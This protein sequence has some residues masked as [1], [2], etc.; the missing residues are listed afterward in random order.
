MCAASQFETKS[1]HPR[2]GAE[3]VGVDF[4][5][6]VANGIVQEIRRLAD[7][8]GLLLFRTTAI[9]SDE[10]QLAF[11]RQL[12]PGE[13]LGERTPRTS[14]A[15]LA[16]GVTAVGNVGDDNEILPLDSRRKAFMRGNELWHTDSSYST[17]RGA[18]S[19]LKAVEIPPDGVAPTQHADMRSAYNDLSESV[20]RRLESLSAVH[21]LPHS[22]EL[23][24][25]HADDSEQSRFPPTLQPLVISNDRTGLH[26]LYLASHIAHIDGVTDAES[27]DLLAQLFEHATRPE[28]IYRHSWAAGDIVM[29]DNLATMH[30]ATPFED[31]RWRRDMHRVTTLEKCGSSQ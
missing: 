17:N 14:E 28:Y 18:Y 12:G 6:P 23:A 26:S 20:K 29:W 10:D 27:A 16:A 2:F 3:V 25:Y 15:R 9:V 30:R 4:S 31:N 7:Q 21:S 22:R 1:L 24:G 5:A 13:I 11:C 19:M 8:Y